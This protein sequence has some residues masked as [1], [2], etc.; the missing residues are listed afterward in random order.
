M[1]GPSIS[2][3]YNVVFLSVL[4]IEFLKQWEGVWL[5]C[6]HSCLATNDKGRTI[7]LSV[8]AVGFLSSLSYEYISCGWVCPNYSSVWESCGRLCKYEVSCSFVIGFLWVLPLDIQLSKSLPPPCPIL[9]MWNAAQYLSNQ[10]IHFIPTYWAAFYIYSYSTL[11]C[12]FKA[13][14]F[15][16]P[17]LRN[18]GV[19]P[20]FLQTCVISCT[21][22][23]GQVSLSHLGV[24]EFMT[25]AECSGTFKLGYCSFGINHPHALHFCMEYYFLMR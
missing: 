3:S 7:Q 10:R 9:A 1:P 22:R 5:K 23:R 4:F 16:S 12:H 6:H 14:K 24:L 11:L 21:E 19:Y 20:S 15:K 13:L 2:T 17:M 8:R 25:P 18:R